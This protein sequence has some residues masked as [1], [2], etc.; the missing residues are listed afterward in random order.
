MKWSRM[1]TKFS[2]YLLLSIFLLAFLPNLATAEIT[3]D[4]T[5]PAYPAADPDPWIL[6][7]DPTGD[8]PDANYIDLIIDGSLEINED[9]GVEDANGYIGFASGS[10]GTVDVV[11]DAYW[12]NYEN[13]VHP[14]EGD[15]YY[16]GGDLYVGYEGTGELNILSDGY[17]WADVNGY[18]GFG[19]D[20]IGSVTVTGEDSEL[21]IDQDL[22]VGYGGEGT[23]V[24]SDGAYVYSGWDTIIGYKPNSTG[25]VTV[26]GGQWIEGEGT[27]WDD[28][29]LEV[30]GELIVGYE[31]D[32]TLLVEE[33]GYV[34]V[35]GGVYIGGYEDA[36]GIVTVTGREI[37]EEDGDG[38]FTGSSQA[39]SELYIDGELVVGYEG[40]ASLL[41]EDGAYV[42]VYD[43]ATIG[44]ESG[45]TG[46]VT[47][48]GAVSYQE[49]TDLDDTAR[50]WIDGSEWEID[51]NLYVG[52][53]GDGELMISDGGG[54]ETNDSAYI[55][56]ESGS[57]GMVTVTGSGFEQVPT[58]E[59]DEDD[60]WWIDGS[61][62]ELVI[63]SMSAM[64]A[65]V[66]C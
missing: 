48:T 62:W 33:G 51:G 54:V 46:M 7:V 47:V 58:G 45:S 59:F 30:D 39:A 42:Y 24:V 20:S 29:E 1:K 32:G 35:D 37:Y 44:M 25:S 21:Y 63:T 55:G 56:Y 50:E 22:Y 36:N 2:V 6:Q 19:P 38:L 11:D 9:S 16:W 26:T 61:E 34:D 57:R 18:I 10:S 13:A 40:N 27:W 17:V 31:G 15:S 53:D 23:M 3:A 4:G 66:S 60:S 64:R 41:I 65:K 8:P 52:Y 28:S 49:S 5:T 43:D 12:Y 14:T